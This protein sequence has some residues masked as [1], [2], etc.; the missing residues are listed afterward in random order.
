MGLGF[1]L[2]PSESSDARQNASVSRQLLD[3]DPEKGFEVNHEELGFYWFAYRK[4]RSN[5]LWN[6][7]RTVE[8]GAFICPG[9]WFTMLAWTYLILGAPVFGIAAAL[10]YGPF[11]WLF[12][13]LAAVPLVLGALA[14]IAHMLNKT[15]FD[16]NF[17]KRIGAIVGGAALS[18]VVTMVLM[19]IH[20][21]RHVAGM[22]VAVIWGIMF[23]AHEADKPWEIPFFG[24]FFS[25]ALPT[26]IGWDVVQAFLRN[27]EWLTTLLTLL[28]QA[29]ESFLEALPTLVAMAAIAIVTV[30]PAVS[31]AKSTDRESK[32]LTARIKHARLVS[33]WLMSMSVL[34]YGLCTL[35]IL[36][37]N[38]RAHAGW[39]I[40]G[41]IL[42]T[43][44]MMAW[45]SVK[46][47]RREAMKEWW[48]H[49]ND[50]RLSKAEPIGK[51]IA[52]ALYHNK[53]LWPENCSR[54]DMSWSSLRF[55]MQIA[56]ADRFLERAKNMQV[57]NQTESLLR[58]QMG[59]VI[60]WCGFLPD[61]PITSS[62]RDKIAAGW[63]PEAVLYVARQEGYL[64]EFR[65]KSLEINPSVAEANGWLAQT[66]YGDSQTE[67]IATIVWERVEGILRTIFTPLFVLWSFLCRVVGD[68]YELWEAFNERCPSAPNRH[69]KAV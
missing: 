36:S 39:F 3:N 59:R 30:G 48:Y 38:Q 15:S 16:V 11:V 55:W 22:W 10:S 42:A 44:A 26:A 21:I 6:T 47:P 18:V 65:G 58:T 68:A 69:R 52:Q 33:R 24:K 63:S 32:P 53:Q 64:K 23:V 4:L 12:G 5:I 51:A 2:Y 37:D 43:V 41:L 46:N 60:W 35:L 7:E 34:G 27:P 20:E 67:R 17:W 31:A 54:P 28:G 13:V 66:E 45:V 61:R 19:L 49:W 8:L 25:F 14:G 29:W 57:V 62:F 56:G 1:P 50:E 9:F 40:G